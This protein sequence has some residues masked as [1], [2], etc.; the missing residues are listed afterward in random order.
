MSFS[1]VDLETAK[2][3]AG[4]RM[5]V[6]GGVPSPWGEAAK[7]YFHVK[8]VDWLATRLTYGDDG[9]K[10]WAGTRS[11]PVAV[12]NDEPPRSGWREILDLAERIAPE[13]A[14][15]PSDPAARS[16]VYDLVERLLGKGGFCWLRRN[17]LVHAGLSGDAEGF[18]PQVAGYLAK[19]YGYTPEI[20]EGAAGAVA[21][22]LSHFADRL[23][24]GRD[25]LVGDALTAA[26]IAFAASMA[27]IAP[28]PPE[29]CAMNE[30]TRKVFARRDPATSASMSPHLLAH[31]DKVYAEAL[32]LPLSL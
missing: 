12:W 7:G 25:W 5:V 6:V 4:L 22:H 10:D 13:P 20:G 9:L 29:Q 2:A 32:Q 11:G 26:D 21:A 27:L 17:Q 18:P 8:G 23:G 31:R 28:L 1:Y 30:V 16:E 15:L 19:K 24:D 3:A 14:L